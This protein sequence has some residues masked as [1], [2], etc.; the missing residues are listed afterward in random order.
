MYIL[1]ASSRVRVSC[2]IFCRRLSTA[3]IPDPI[4]AVPPAE[5]VFSSAI[6]LAPRSAASTAAAKPAVPADTTTTSAA[7]CFIV[8]SP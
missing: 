3:K 8:F 6:T 2:K 7:I 5:D 1:K 4:L